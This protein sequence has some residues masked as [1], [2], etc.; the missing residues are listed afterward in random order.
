MGSKDFTSF[1][2]VWNCP[3]RNKITSYLN[4]GFCLCRDAR[5]DES[6]AFKASFSARSLHNCSSILVSASSFEVRDRA[7]SSFFKLRYFIV[8]L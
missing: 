3:S 4:E 8:F 7:A 2:Y 6:F 1:I 5:I